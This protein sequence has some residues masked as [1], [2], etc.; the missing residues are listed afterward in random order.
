MKPPLVGEQGL[1]V[2]EP[3]RFF[4]LP[5]VSDYRRRN[6]GIKSESARR[7]PFERRPLKRKHQKKKKKKKKKNVFIYARLRSPFSY[8][9]ATAATA[10]VINV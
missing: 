9:A 4:F 5:R 2:L 1:F 10:P 8:L 3:N 6:W 7:F